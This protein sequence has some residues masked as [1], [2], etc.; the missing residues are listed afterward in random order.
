MDANARVVSV[1]MNDK[2]EATDIV[3]AGVGTSVVVSLD[4]N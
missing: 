4:G 3:V 2:S 1:R